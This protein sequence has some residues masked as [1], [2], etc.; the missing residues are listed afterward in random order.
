MKRSLPRSDD[1]SAPRESIHDIEVISIRAMKGADTD[2]G[3]R[4]VKR[5]LRLVGLLYNPMAT[6]WVV[7]TRVA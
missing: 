3:T 7:S 6:R 1:L 5:H 4:P 2:Q